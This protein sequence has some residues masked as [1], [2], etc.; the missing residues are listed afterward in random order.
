MGKSAQSTGRKRRYCR[1]NPS[2]HG[3]IPLKPIAVSTAVRGYPGTLPARML[4]ESQR[5]HTLSRLGKVPTA[6]YCT[7]LSRKDM[8]LVPAASVP[9]SNPGSAKN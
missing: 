6:G 2:L 9:L 5:K 7:Y 1:H 4:E 3:S 8:A